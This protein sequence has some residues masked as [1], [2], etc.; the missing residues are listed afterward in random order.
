V[1][2]QPLLHPRNPHQGRYDFAALIAKLPALAALVHKNPSGE[3]T[4]DF[5]N[6]N[7]VLLLNQ[8]LLA[9]YYQ[10]KYWQLPA[11]YLC[12]P[13]PGRAD[14]VHYLADVLA[15]SC[16]ALATGKN[17]NLLDIGTGANVIYP[18][19]ACQSYGWNVTASEIDPVALKVANTIVAANV[20]LKA[21]IRIVTQPDKAAIFS[22][23]IEPP[24]RFHLTMCNPPFFS[25]K[26]E[27]EQASVRKWTN[28][29]KQATT[30]RNFAGQQHELWCDGGELAF[31]RQMINESQLFKQQVCWFSSLVSQQKHLAPLQKL[32]RSVGAIQ[33]DV[34]EMRQG[35]KV[36]RIL[37]WSY[38][39][40]QQQLQW[41]CPS[42]P[43]L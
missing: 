8:A 16:G 27:A 35:Q 13:I 43:R 40:P 29:G 6:S 22:G 7:A 10:V 41:S 12:P 19:I 17:V 9:T 21:R 15:S 11:G 39:S 32:L 5:A 4:I 3:P 36:S 18:I 25:S 2:S 38:L 31:I 14:Y 23:V 34:I 30:E 42:A 26:A 1:S 28:L 20:A 37:L 24:Q 33:T